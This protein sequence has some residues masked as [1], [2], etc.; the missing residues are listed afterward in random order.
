MYGGDSDIA[1]VSLQVFP[2]VCQDRT[3]VSLIFLLWAKF[4]GT[5]LND[6]GR[7][8]TIPESGSRSSL[9]KWRNW[10]L[11]CTV[12]VR[13][14]LNRRRSVVAIMCCGG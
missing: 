14:L 11:L 12:P 6:A 9:R 13:L 4:A 7:W 3:G 1:V 8:V 5:T 10:G 2:F